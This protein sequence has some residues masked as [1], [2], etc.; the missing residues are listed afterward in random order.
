MS[1][2][3]ISLLS[4]SF[5]LAKRNLKLGVVKL[6]LSTHPGSIRFYSSNSYTMGPSLIKVF[7]SSGSRVRAARSAPNYMSIYFLTTSAIK[8]KA[9]PANMRKLM[10]ILNMIAVLIFLV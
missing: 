8:V 9:V 4:S 3:I 6:Q 7:N 2:I 1:E 5:I 10:Q